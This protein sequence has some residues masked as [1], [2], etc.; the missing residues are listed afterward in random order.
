MAERQKKEQ[1]ST[2]I[3][4]K[5]GQLK[6]SY[7]E[8]LKFRPQTEDFFQIPQFAQGLNETKTFEEKDTL[9][10]FFFLKSMLN[11]K[12]S[13]I[14]LASIVPNLY[15]G[16]GTQS[17]IWLKNGNH[18]PGLSFLFNNN[19]LSLEEIGYTKGAVLVCNIDIRSQ[20]FLNYQLVETIIET[21]TD[22]LKAKKDKT[23]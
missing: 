1:E 6:K 22:D 3:E 16:R 2:L 14:L 18:G 4:K 11:L 15:M 20:D 10:Q 8:L 9:S 5:R 12:K 21:I 23:P 19:N 17:R 7:D 13:N